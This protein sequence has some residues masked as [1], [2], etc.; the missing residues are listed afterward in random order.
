METK[1]CCAVELLPHSAPQ[2]T[3]ELY[4]T[5]I[6]THLL[7]QPLSYRN[8]LRFC[9]RD[10]QNRSLL[11]QIHLNCHNRPIVELDRL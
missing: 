10:G 2:D 8:L 1:P 6:Q 11:H 5:D 9:S 7:F 3:R 4:Q